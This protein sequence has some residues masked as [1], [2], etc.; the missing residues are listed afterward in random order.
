MKKII[1]RSVAVFLFILCCS[2]FSYEVLSSSPEIGY[3]NPSFNSYD[4]VMEAYYDNSELWSFQYRNYWDLTILDFDDY[5]SIFN[6]VV[7]SNMFA[8]FAEHPE[9]LPSEIRVEAFWYSRYSI[10]YSYENF[11][12]IVE[13]TKDTQ[14]ENAI[15]SGNYKKFQII[16]SSIEKTEYFNGCDGCKRK[17]QLPETFVLN[18]EKCKLY[19]WNEYTVG[20]IYDSTAVTVS[21]YKTEEGKRDVTKDY[22]R[23][24]ISDLVFSEYIPPEDN[25]GTDGEG[26]SVE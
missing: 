15:E 9:R 16:R 2:S 1:R 14:E 20:F 4:E 11:W 8:Y 24:F 12:I 17:L 22:V 6:S 19:W 26:A 5:C 3:L 7:E 10:K 18:G 13:Y 25:G 23:E 21:V